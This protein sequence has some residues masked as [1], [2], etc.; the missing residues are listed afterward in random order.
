[1]FI[2]SVVFKAL[3]ALLHNFLRFLIEKYQ[4]IKNLLQLS[5]ANVY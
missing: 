1:M 2:M 5:L 3:L 4:L